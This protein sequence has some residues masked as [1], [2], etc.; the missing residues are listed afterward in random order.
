[1]RPFQILF[2]MLTK[3][4][5]FRKVMRKWSSKISE[6]YQLGG[7]ILAGFLDPSMVWDA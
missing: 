4:L 3:K 2:Y 1:M 5:A 7:V 6:K